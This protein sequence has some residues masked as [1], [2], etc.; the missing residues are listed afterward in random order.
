M[1]PNGHLYWRSKN[2]LLLLYE[3]SDLLTTKTMGQKPLGVLVTR[4]TSRLWRRFVVSTPW[5]G[6]QQIWTKGPDKKGSTRSEIPINEGRGHTFGPSGVSCSDKATSMSL[7]VVTY[8]LGFL[9]HID[10]DSVLV[11]PWK[12]FLNTN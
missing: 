3:S 6:S 5:G 2:W 8:R 7:E 12:K 9:K 1:S 4:S 11:D 10:D